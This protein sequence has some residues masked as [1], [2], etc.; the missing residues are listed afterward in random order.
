METTGGG[1]VRTAISRDAG[2]LLGAVQRV[3]KEARRARHGY[4]FPLLLSGLIILGDLPFSYFS[5]GHY[6]GSFNGFWGLCLCSPEGNHPFGSTLYWLIAIP[7]GFA[8]VAVYYMMR[9]RRTGLQVKIWPYVVTGSVLFLLLIMTA[10]QVPDPFRFMYRLDN[11]RYYAHVNQGYTP[12]L[13]VSV[14]FFALARLERSWVLWLTT[15]MFFAVAILANTY[16]ISNIGQRIHWLWPGWAANLSFAGGF[17]VF[18]G[19]VSLIALGSG[20]GRHG[21]SG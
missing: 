6:S 17:L 8:V 1:E 14:A 12:V 9:A 4:W 19:L 11:W 16:N 15:L 20:S 3:S 10:A 5:L 2:E 18:V 21:A 13:V 7:L